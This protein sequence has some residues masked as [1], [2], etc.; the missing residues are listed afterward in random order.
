MIEVAK[1]DS[2]NKITNTFAI[3][4]A[5]G[6]DATG[7]ITQ[8][9]IKEYCVAT[10][11]GT[12]DEYVGNLPSVGGTCNKDDMYD[13]SLNCFHE[14]RPKDMTGAPCSSWTLQ[15]DGSWEPPHNYVRNL[16]DGNDY[17]Y[18]KVGDVM[19]GLFTRRE[20]TQSWY[21]KKHSEYKDGDTS[22]VF[23]KFDNTDKTWKSHSDF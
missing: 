21:A 4:K 2:N 17:N 23:Y 13:A 9:K 10:F 12:A 5:Y 8:S 1:L 22:A 11:G 18:E 20:A 16:D 7:A 15:A 19:Y 6:T 3:H 14:P